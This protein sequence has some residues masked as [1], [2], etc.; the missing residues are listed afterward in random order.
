MMGSA[1]IKPSFKKF[2]EMLVLEHDNLVGM[3]ILHSSKTKSLVVN[4][5][6]LSGKNSNKKQK[7]SKVEPQDD[8]QKSSSKQQSSSNQS[9][10]TQ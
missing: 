1:Y 7:K 2:S 6:N 3:G 8:T 9:S 5:G 4:E 10:S